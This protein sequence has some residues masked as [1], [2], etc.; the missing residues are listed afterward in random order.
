[1]SE[2]QAGG[3]PKVL[4]T[5]GAGVVGSYVVRDLVARGDRP[6]VVDVADGARLRAEMADAIVYH[7]ADFA[8][9]GALQ[10]ICERHGITTILHLGGLTGAASNDRPMVMFRSN[11]QGTMHVLE[12]ARITGVKR[13]VMASTRTV[14]PDFD[15]TPY[16]HPTYR[17]VPEDHSLEPTRPYEVWKHAS[18]R[19]GRFYRE[20]WGI[21]FA[22][23][24]FAIYF[25]AERTLDPGGRAMGMLHQM[26]GNAV[27]GRPTRFPGG[28]DRMMD[29]VYVR[30]LA[31]AFIAA[32]SA[33]TLPHSVYNI[34]RGEPV[35]PG[36]FAAAVAAAVPR[37]RIDV[38]PGIDFAPGHYCV[39]D[40]SR[41]RRDF[42]YAPRWPLAAAVADCAAR[43]RTLLDAARAG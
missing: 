37:A 25:A 21:A 30:D 31:S 20:Q 10:T 36:Q 35:T 18:E 26:I 40:I 27:A 6:V 2:T 22:A 43:T 5:G 8:D 33:P 23:F 41:A 32:A 17:P 14:Y 4:V 42:G 28:A 11:M 19:M 16:G 15:G 34:G 3:A 24:R 12:A 1:V 13:V 39:L 9:P 7:Q 29:C 38:G